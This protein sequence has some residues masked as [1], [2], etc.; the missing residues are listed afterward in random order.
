MKKKN[1]FYLFLFVVLFCF[2]SCSD[3]QQKNT[4]IE[5]PNELKQRESE[6]S[7]EITQL[8]EQAINGVDSAQL[9]LA[10]KYYRGIE[11]AVNYDKAFQWLQIA[12]KSSNTE[13]KYAAIGA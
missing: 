7:I 3:S 4:Q 12:S 5:I 1:F 8:R 10:Y 11:I 6:E 9:E 13:I 2:V